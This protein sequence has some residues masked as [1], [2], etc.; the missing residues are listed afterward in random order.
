MT[1]MTHAYMHVRFCRCLLCT[2]VRAV[3]AATNPSSALAD[4]IVS[5]AQHV[6]SLWDIVHV[7]LC[8]GAWF[9]VV[10][11]HYWAVWRSWR[12]FLWHRCG[13]WLTWRW[14]RKLKP[15]TSGIYI[16][17]LLVC[18]VLTL[19]IDHAKASFTCLTGHKKPLNAS[20]MEQICHSSFANSLVL[21]HCFCPF[22]VSTVPNMN[23][24]LRKGFYQHCSKT[25]PHHL[26]PT[27]HLHPPNACLSVTLALIPYRW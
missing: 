14:G 24:T 21:K 12:A 16:K 9:E 20:D 15:H 2:A 13:K 11:D 18:L 23:I 17:I 27:Q 25:S 4:I 8:I 3:S 19:C 22:A 6:H 10:S 5:K 7:P 1:C 26:K